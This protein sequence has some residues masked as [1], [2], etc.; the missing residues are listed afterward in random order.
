MIGAEIALRAS[1]ADQA[2]YFLLIFP[3]CFAW[4][5]LPLLLPESV[6]PA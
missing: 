1:R 6:L 5:L 4:R 2:Y 3:L